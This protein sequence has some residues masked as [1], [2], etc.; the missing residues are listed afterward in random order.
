MKM[1]LDPTA[2]A[3]ASNSLQAIPFYTLI[4]APLQAAVQAQAA[5]AQSTAD[6]IQSVGID[7][8]GA[9]INVVFQFVQN[10]QTM[11]LTVPLLAIVPIPYIEIN[12]MTIDFTANLSATSSSLNTADNSANSAYG[13]SAQ[14]NCSYGPFSALANFTA[15]YSNQSA[16]TASESSQYDVQYLMDIHVDAGAGDLP[17]G[18]KTILNVISG[19]TVATPTLSISAAPDAG[20]TNQLDV[21]VTDPSNSSTNGVLLTATVTQAQASTFAITAGSPATYN[22]TPVNFTLGLAQNAT[23][24]TSTTPVQLIVTATSV[25]GG[26]PA[27][28]PVTVTLPYTVTQ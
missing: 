20:T 12:N 1:S 19:A 17:A 22:G 23:A 18:M 4:G 7:A 28:L 24:P 11:V 27:P 10:G 5:A 8:N 21:S 3:T 26:S 6:Y 25:P 2:A 16:A 13:G 15:N 14:F 9:P